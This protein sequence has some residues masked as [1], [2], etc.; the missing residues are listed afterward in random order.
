MKKRFILT[1]IISAALVL[2][3]CTKIEQ[4]PAEPKISFT[5]FTVFDTIDILGNEAK[6]GRL[7]FYFEDGDGNMGLDEPASGDEDSTNMFLTL[8]RKTNGTMVPAEDNDV[9]K[10]SDYR[11]PYME[12]TGVNR[13]LKGTISITFIYLFW[14]PADTIKYDFYIEDRALN[15]SNI[16][17]TS[18]IILG[19]TGEYLP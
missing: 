7:K 5:S 3:E 19:R 14:S 15:K 10:P 2:P 1:A 17:S 16:A 6:G 18:E 13:I 9:L 12:R 8:Y 4:L 11:I